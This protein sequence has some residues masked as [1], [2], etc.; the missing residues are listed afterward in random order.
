MQRLV[1]EHFEFGE[2]IEPHEP[3]VSQRETVLSPMLHIGTPDTVK[4]CNNLMITLQPIA[5]F[6]CNTVRTHSQIKAEPLP[7]G[8][9]S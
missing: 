6:E 2:P 1:P 9:H 3:P 4:S 5:H 7:N 8:K